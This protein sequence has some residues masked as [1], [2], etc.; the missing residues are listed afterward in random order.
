MKSPLLIKSEFNLEFEKKWEARQARESYQKER[1]R[2]ASQRRAVQRCVVTH[3]ALAVRRLKQTTRSVDTAVR[4]ALTT[5]QPLRILILTEAPETC[6]WWAEDCLL[7]NIALFCSVWVSSSNL[8]GHLTPDCLISVVIHKSI[9]G[10]DFSVQCSQF[11]CYTDMSYFV[12]LL[13][14]LLKIVRPKTFVL[15]IWTG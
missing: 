11:L 13:G 2:Q 4:L 14:R 10:K 8:L 1:K 7:S 6:L 3:R 9:S 15:A 12:L 5:C